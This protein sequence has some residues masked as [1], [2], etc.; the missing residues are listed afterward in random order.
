V[1]A[2]QRLSAAYPSKTEYPKTGLA[3]DM[4]LVAKL[5]SGGAATRVFYTQVGGFDDHANEKDQHARVLKEVDGAIGAFYDDLAA[6]GM[7]DRVVTAVFSEFGRRVKENGSGGTD[8]GTAAPMFV[9]GGR[10]KGGLYG[11]YPSLSNLDNGDLK[12]DVDFRSV[13]YTLVDNWLKGDAQGVLGKTYE[14]L[15]FV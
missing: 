3:R 8:H 10:V 1:E 15:A 13:Y 12:Y 11:D 6:L 7:Q 5:L 9:V 2:V 14:K 4:Q